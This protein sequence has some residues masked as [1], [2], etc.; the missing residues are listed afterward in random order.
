MHPPFLFSLSCER[1]E[2][3]AVHGPKRKENAGARICPVGKF[4]PKKYGGCSQTVPGNLPVFCRLRLTA[5]R[6]GA[7]CRRSEY[8]RGCFAALTQGP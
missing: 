3:R 6:E 7:L 8:Q 5:Y 2:K 4:R 1:K